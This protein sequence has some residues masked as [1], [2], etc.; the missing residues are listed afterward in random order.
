MKKLYILLGILVSQMT[1]VF[2]DNSQDVI[3]KNGKDGL[4]LALNGDSPKK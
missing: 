3:I 2:A 1:F 4:D